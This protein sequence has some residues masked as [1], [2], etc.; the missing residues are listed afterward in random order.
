MSDAKLRILKMLEDNKISADEAARLLAALDKTDTEVP[1][2]KA[3]FLKIRIFVGDQDKPKV[4]V[5]VPVSVAKLAAKLGGKF[6]MAIPEEAKEKMREKGVELNEET[7]ENL[8]EL[9][10][11]LAVNGRYDLVH[12][13]DGDDLVKIYIE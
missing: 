10:E 2:K 9:F 7:F 8:D 5:T 1:S 3:R 13:E 6:Q 4:K 11:E 12:V